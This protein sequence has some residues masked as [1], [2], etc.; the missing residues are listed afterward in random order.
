MLDQYHYDQWC[1]VGGG[2]GQSKIIFIRDNVENVDSDLEVAW[3]WSLMRS[4]YNESS[5]MMRFRLRLLSDALPTRRMLSFRNAKVSDLCPFCC[6]ALGPASP[7]PEHSLQHI[8][9]V[10]GGD[11]CFL[12]DTGFLDRFALAAESS[13]RACM[14][15]RRL[16]SVHKRWLAQFC[17][18]YAHGIKRRVLNDPAVDPMIPSPSGKR[19]DILLLHPTLKLPLSTVYSV[20]AADIVPPHLVSRWAYQQLFKR[21]F[22][23][24]CEVL[25][26]FK[27]LV[28]RAFSVEHTV[29]LVFAPLATRHE[30]LHVLPVPV[31]LA[32]IQAGLME[33]PALAEVFFDALWF[34]DTDDN[35]SVRVMRQLASAVVSGDIGVLFMVSSCSHVY[36]N[37]T[38][39]SVLAHFPAGVM[40]V[41]PLA[42]AKR[43]TTGV[44]ALTFL[45][46]DCYFHC[47]VSSDVGVQCLPSVPE[48][49][50]DLVTAWSEVH[51]M[52][53][54]YAAVDSVQMPDYFMPGVQLMSLV[55]KVILDPTAMWNCFAWTGFLPQERPLRALQRLPEFVMMQSL[56]QYQK[57]LCMLPL[58]V[59]KI[60]ESKG[61]RPRTA[62]KLL[63]MM[64]RRTRSF[65]L[66]TWIHHC[67][68]LAARFPHPPGTFN[69]RP[70]IPI[71]LVDSSD[72]EEEEDGGQPGLDD[73]NDPAQV[74]VGDELLAFNW[75]RDRLVAMAE[76]ELSDD[77]FL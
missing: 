49:W 23:S 8:L 77:G 70:R 61:F 28:F 32:T 5:A 35:V 63:K 31:T 65:L 52:I 22:A 56:T 9:G 44:K 12:T 3:D 62:V 76:D 14:H 26:A 48:N 67:T 74:L 68:E 73:E 21:P 2:A 71:R 72:S 45:Q 7:I 51:C 50:I 38:T 59:T 43:S 20:I 24:S 4:N 55:P 64:H 75:H 42:G 16:K 30:T 6:E 29:A 27:R 40:P 1:E 41:S 60:F 34:S 19:G 25:P 69:P 46:T 18:N 47:I 39:A 66:S 10:D 36:M 11:V 58:G 53:P 54:A 13:I 57:A 37:G 33:L 15:P 17:D